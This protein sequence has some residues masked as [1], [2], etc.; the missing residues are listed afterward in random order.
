LLEEPEGVVIVLGAK[1]S[2]I[3]FAHDTR[4]SQ[5]IEV[6]ARRSWQSTV[7]CHD[8]HVRAVLDGLH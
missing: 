1:V 7:R 8:K 6:P 5:Q 3:E 2:E 4:F